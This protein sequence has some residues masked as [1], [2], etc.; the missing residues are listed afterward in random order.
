MCESDREP[1]RRTGAGGGPWLLIAFGAFGAAL[2]VTVAV[3]TYSETP[4]EEIRRSEFQELLLTEEMS[5]RAT[6]SFVKLCQALSS[7]VDLS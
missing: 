7:F 1:N 3:L 4:A 2:T 6:L 5:R